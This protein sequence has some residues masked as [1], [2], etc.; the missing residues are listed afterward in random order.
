MITA[1]PGAIAA[2]PG[3]AALPFFGVVPAILDEGGRELA[4][5]AEGVLCIKSTWPGVLRTIYGDQ[6]RAR[7]ATVPRH[8]SAVPRFRGALRT[9]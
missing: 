4:G 7:R 5:A 6:A 9:T 2:K 1:L 3:S 8:G